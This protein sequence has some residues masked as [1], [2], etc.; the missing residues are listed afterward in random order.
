MTVMLLTQILE[1][2]RTLIKLTAQTWHRNMTTLLT[3][4]NKRHNVDH[5]LSPS[6]QAALQKEN[7]K[8][9]CITDIT[10]IG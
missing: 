3:L 4:C 9:Y 1:Y 7:R 10:W 5:P 8:K 6:L 2:K